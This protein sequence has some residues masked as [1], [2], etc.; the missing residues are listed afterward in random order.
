MHI[1]LILNVCLLPI[2]RVS[3]CIVTRIVVYTYVLLRWLGNEI[4]DY[5]VI[6][7]I[8]STRMLDTRKWL[9]AT[10][11][12]ACFFPMELGRR[13]DCVYKQYKNFRK[14]CYDTKK[15][16]NDFWISMCLKVWKSESLKVGVTKIAIYWRWTRH[17]HTQS[18]IVTTDESLIHS[19]QN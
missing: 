6:I 4:R 5:R 2:T 10:C 1:R 7:R 14:P 3:F 13:G 18:F 17:T 9:L 16:T 19:M 12:N 15:R 11:V 8:A